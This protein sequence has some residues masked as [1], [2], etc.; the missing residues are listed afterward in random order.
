MLKTFAAAVQQPV[1]DALHDSE[2]IAPF[3]NVDVQAGLRKRH[4]LRGYKTQGAKP[5]TSSPVAVDGVDIA[6]PLAVRPT[7]TALMAAGTIRE[8]R[9]ESQVITENDRTGSNLRIPSRSKFALPSVDG[10]LDVTYLGQRI[11]ARWRVNGSRS[12]TI[13]LGRP[14]MSSIGRPD[15]S[16]W[17][18]VSGTSVAIEE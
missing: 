12:G 16:I 17:M 2:R 6:P 11:E 14:I 4:G 18:R 7:P 8:S 1:R 9:I 13:G 15:A 3:A 10:Y 5:A